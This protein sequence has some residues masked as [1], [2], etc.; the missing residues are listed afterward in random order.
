[1][2]LHIRNAPTA[3]MQELGYGRGYQYAHDF[4]EAIVPQDYLPDEL[5]G[6]VFYQPTE[7]GYEKLVKERLER[8]RKLRRNA[9]EKEAE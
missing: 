8:W 7:R 6:R 1:V 4:K 2:P 3:L 9:S 5:K